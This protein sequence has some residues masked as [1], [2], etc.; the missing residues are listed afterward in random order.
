MAF[1]FESKSWSYTGTKEFENGGFTLLNPTVS[2][3]SVSVQSSNVYIAMKAVENNGVYNHNLNIQYNNT[4]GETNLD[5]IVDA[6]V[7]AALPDF[8]LDA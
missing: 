7:A 4:G 3:L 1:A 6:A 5:T 2:V 8:T